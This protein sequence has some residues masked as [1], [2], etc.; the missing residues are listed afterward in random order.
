M[1][2]KAQ[3]TGGSE[4]NRKQL[5]FISAQVSVAAA[6]NPQEHYFGLAPMVQIAVHNYPD[7][8]V[9][10]L[11]NLPAVRMKADLLKTAAAALQLP[12]KLPVCSPAQPARPPT[13]Q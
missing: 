3:G 8:T 12:A 11:T 2:D 5:N 6:E 13:K 7:M 10:F 1:I 4:D 9:D